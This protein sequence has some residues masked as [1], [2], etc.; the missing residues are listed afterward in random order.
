M[1]LKIA[2]PINTVVYTSMYLIWCPPPQRMCKNDNSFKI[3]SALRVLR[4]AQ[5]QNCVQQDRIYKT[6]NLQ[7]HD[8]QLPDPV[9]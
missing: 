5:V 2:S 9:G 1:G 3:L 4:V 8:F 7:P 6:S